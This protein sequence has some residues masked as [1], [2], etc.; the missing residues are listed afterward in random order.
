MP[1][2]VKPGEKRT[3]EYGGGGRLVIGQATT[4]PSGVQVNWQ[5][6]NHVLNLKQKPLPLINPDDFATAAAYQ[7][8]QQES[9]KSEAQIRH[10][11]EARAYQLLFETDGSFRVE[12]VPPGLFELRI[13]LTK[14]AGRE[15]FR[16]YTKPEDELGALIT[17][18]TIP[19]GTNTFD[20]GTVVVEMKAAQELA[21]A[22][23]LKLEAST[24][25]GHAL[26]LDQFHGRHVLLTF[27]TPWSERSTE[28]LSQI[29]KL[30]EQYAADKRIQ[31]LG[32]SI[33]EDVEATREAVRHRGYGGTQ[34][35]IEGK[36]LADAAAAFNVELLP[37]VF[38][39]DPQG[40]LISRDLEGQRLQQ[41][42]ERALK[43]K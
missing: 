24:L 3:V 27:W 38:L 8:A 31:F 41:A 18:V 36:A 42:V 5:N 35:R 39:L 30:Q 28:Q 13:Q 4:E 17:D 25:D 32:V 21:K 37:A 2:T 11:R 9:Y 34:A 10:V 14:P 19:P 20:L 23:P 6:D 26:H 22:A 33:D 1:I 43:S 40:R 15:S 16:G 12:D 7:K 29:E